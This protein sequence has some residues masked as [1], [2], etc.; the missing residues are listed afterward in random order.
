ML[1][2]FY[3]SE[4]Q[5]NGSVKHKYLKYSTSIT[6]P[7][8]FWN[9][10]RQRVKET[11]QYP[12]YVV[13]NEVLSKFDSDINKV[14]RRFR[15]DGIRP[16][17]Q[18]LKEEL[19]KIC[20]PSPVVAKIT[21]AS[22]IEYFIKNTN[23]KKGTITSYQSTLKHIRNFQKLTGREL[24][25]EDI[26]IDFY[27]KFVRFLKNQDFTTNTIGKSIKNIKVF[28]NYAVEN[29]ITTNTKH[30]SKGFKAMQDEPDNIYLSDSEID[31]LYNLDLKDNPR[32]D[33]VRDL[34]VIDCCTGL[35]YMDLSK[36]SK[37]HFI[38]DNTMLKITTEKTSEVVIIPLHDYVVEI[39][40]KYKNVL[41]TVPSDQKLNLYLKEIGKIAGITEQI[42]ISRNKGGIRYDQTYSKYEKITVHTGRRSFA[43]NGYLSGIEVISLMKITG[44]R[45]ERAFMKYIKIDKLQN[46]NILMTHKFFRKRANQKAV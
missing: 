2:Y 17:P 33:K 26:D 9:F 10:D 38:N 20:K 15:D 29:G 25:F 1:F 21:F 27:N 37:E 23:N 40:D 3:Y 22:F 36:L 13:I 14:Y 7:V 12:E 8:K 5:P 42:Q 39:L 24:Q 18:M 31:A 44:H 34:F 19:I 16:N 43:T 45:T 4:T 30:R 28:M 46:A 41:P 6:I 11:S 32:L 35:R